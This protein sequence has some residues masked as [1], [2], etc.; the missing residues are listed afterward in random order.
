MYS[1]Y[2]PNHKYYANVILLINFRL[3]VIYLNSF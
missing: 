1:M 3:C 2:I